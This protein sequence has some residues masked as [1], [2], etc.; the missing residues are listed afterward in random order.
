[1]A[2]IGTVKNTKRTIEENKFHVK[3]KYGQNFLTDQFILNEI[4]DIPE[5][6][7]NTLVVEIGPGL[8]SM[9]ELL[10]N[11]AKI[12]LAYEI[13]KDLIPIL[14]N[15]FKNQ[16]FYLINDDV[17][18]RNIDKDIEALNGEFDKVVLISNLPYYITTAIVMKVLE[19][20]NIISELVIMMQYEVAM[21][22]TSKPSTK[23]Y[24]SLSVIIQFKTDSKIAL[25]VPKSVFIPI[26]NVDSAVVYMKIKEEYDLKPD[27]LELFYKIVKKSFTQRRKTLVNNISIAF[28]L[29]KS[30]IID[31]LVELGHNE[32]VRAE[33]LSVSEFVELAN[34]FNREIS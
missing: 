21:R 30:Q 14:E 7:E 15:N 33:K 8:G 9:T 20:S 1:M 12:V 16:N 6:T 3:K 5:I 22:F 28:N 24:N 26:P 4:T 29:P 31:I 10:L 11:K 19:E 25:K 17:L 27:N 2:K 18:K 34:M 23:D 13:D 32:M